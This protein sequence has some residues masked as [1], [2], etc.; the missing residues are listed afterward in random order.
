MFFIISFKLLYFSKDYKCNISKDTIYK[1]NFNDN[2]TI[3][4]LLN[5][6]YIVK[7]MFEPFFIEIYHLHSRCV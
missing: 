2:T 5:N 1:N 7:M 3:I 6:E 4:E